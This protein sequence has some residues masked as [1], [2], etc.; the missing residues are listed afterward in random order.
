MKA[1]DIKDSDDQKKSI[2]FTTSSSNET[3]STGTT[4]LIFDSS[5]STILHDKSNLKKFQ[6]Q[7]VSEQDKSKES[8]NADYKASYN[9]PYSASNNEIYIE[10]KLAKYYSVLQNNLKS[11]N[12]KLQNNLFNHLKAAQ[13]S[14]D[15]SVSKVLEELKDVRNS[16]L[17]TI[18]LFAA[19]FTFA[20]V[21]V[22]IF[23]K[24]EGVIHAV[25][26]M[27][28]MWLCIIGLISLFFYFLNFKKYE[29]RVNKF[30]N[31]ELITTFLCIILSCC[32]VY[33]LSN[34]LDDKKNKVMQEKINELIIQN[35]NINITNE[36]LKKEINNLREDVYNLKRNQFNNSLTNQ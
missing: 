33:F 16:V 19:F 14:L 5:S 17:G 12:K 26:L 25:L 13:G 15:S 24:A 31:P 2:S 22:N 34:S 18:A 32:V 29:N 20:S 6:Y 35:K 3:I 4:G 10:K 21:N 8:K 28:S 36:S 30:L 9:N 27:F 23:T 7:G 1:P 11:E